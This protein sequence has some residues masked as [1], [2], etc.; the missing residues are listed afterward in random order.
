MPDHVQQPLAIFD[1]CGTLFREDTTLGF[2]FFFT[3]KHSRP[4][5]LLLNGL[6][7]R[8]SPLLWTLMVV[9]RLSGRHVAKHLAVLQLANFSQ[10]LVEQ[11]AEAYVD[12]LLDR[13]IQPAVFPLFKKS[14]ESGQT[15]LASASLEPVIRALANRFQ[16]D[17][18]ASSLGVR[19]GLY[20]GR[21][22]RDMTGQKLVELRKRYS[23]DWANRDR[24][25]YTDNFSDAELCRDCGRRTVI[26]L[27]PGHRSRW[28]SLE[29]TYLEAERPQ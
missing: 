8:R 3:K 4:R 11:E 1:V 6:F 7:H 22:L 25:C 21:L 23:T 9:E 26:L 14:L 15:V 29:A 12:F 2:L 24:H 16:V 27:K 5:W 17:Y 18:L 19:N 13:R 10:S 20:T 28:G